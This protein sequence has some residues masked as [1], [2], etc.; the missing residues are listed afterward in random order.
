MKKEK[1]NHQRAFEWMLY[2]IV[3]VI[4]IHLLSNFVP[5]I[6]GKYNYCLAIK[7]NIADTLFLFFPI[8]I[9]ISIYYDLF[10]SSSINIMVNRKF[11][12][13]PI[14]SGIIIFV[15]G[16]FIGLKAFHSFIEPFLFYSFIL[17]TFI[18]TIIIGAK[19]KSIYFN[20]DLRD[21]SIKVSQLKKDLKNIKDINKDL[22]KKL[23]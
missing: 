12:F 3:S 8:T 21:Y 9:I 5:R 15:S 18:F 16:L 22:R 6:F 2:T 23:K 1:I 11:F 17:S 10:F 14:C 13:L 19:L 20:I 4:A 7:N